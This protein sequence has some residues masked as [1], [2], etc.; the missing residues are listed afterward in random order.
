MS[1]PRILRMPNA[2]RAHGSSPLVIPRDGPD[3]W[4]RPTVGVH[5]Q[6]LGI[7]TPDLLFL[8]EETSGDMAPAIDG[9]SVGNWTTQ[10]SGH[11]YEQTVAGWTSKFLGLDGSGQQRWGTTGSALD[12]SL[13]ESY[14]MLAYASFDMPLVDTS[15]IIIVQGT[16]NAVIPLETT[17]RVRFRWNALSATGTL[18][19]SGLST[20]HMYGMSRRADIDVTELVTDLETMT[21][22]HDE[23]AWAGEVKGI[24]TPNTTSTPMR[25]C[26]V[27]IWKGANA[28]FDMARAMK[29]L[30]G[31]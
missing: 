18:D 8:C 15:R 30:R 13:G 11:L 31:E 23:S 12:L 25:F 26:L 1:V 27:A 10:G 16:N 9:L 5:F 3:G 17:G 24:G 6:A 14:A 29:I 22:T 19:H 7:N 21:P 4:F 2:P 20:V 28:E